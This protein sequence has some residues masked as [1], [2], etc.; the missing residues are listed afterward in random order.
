M[1]AVNTDNFLNEWLNGG[2]INSASVKNLLEVANDL[3][4][5]SIWV[6]HH[7]AKGELKVNVS[8]LAEIEKQKEYKAGWAWNKRKE[9]EKYRR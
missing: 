3:K 8:L 9:L 2:V 4:R 7:L 6:Y 5:Q 1:I